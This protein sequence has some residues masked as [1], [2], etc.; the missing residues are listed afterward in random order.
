ML[1]TV[2]TAV[3]EALPDDRRNSDYN[4]LLVGRGSEK[5]AAAKARP[6]TF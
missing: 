4:S 6:P 1:A 3:D 5:D 2:D